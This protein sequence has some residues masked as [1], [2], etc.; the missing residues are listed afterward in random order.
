MGDMQKEEIHRRIF[1]LDR[2]YSQ[3]F[4]FINYIGIPGNALSLYKE[5]S[6]QY[7]IPVLTIYDTRIVSS[8][9]YCNLSFV[10]FR[11]CECFLF[12]LRFQCSYFTLSVM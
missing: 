3:F 11:P 4:T 9:I 8:W 7:M 2:F 10:S 1:F 6:L 12:S 5:S